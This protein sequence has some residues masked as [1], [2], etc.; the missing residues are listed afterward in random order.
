M[1][2]ITLIAV[3]N[4]IQKYNVNIGWNFIDWEN[5]SYSIQSTINNKPVATTAIDYIYSCSCSF[6]GE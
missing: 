3:E 6:N 1:K 2:L 5:I 4:Y